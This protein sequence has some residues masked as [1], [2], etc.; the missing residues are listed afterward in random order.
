MTDQGTDQETDQETD[1]G[2]DHQSVRQDMAHTQQ[3][4]G[5]QFGELSEQLASLLQT[6]Q[7]IQTS[8]SEYQHAIQKLNKQVLRSGREQLKANSL[9]EA[10]QQQVAEALEMLQQADE[11]R[12]QELLDT[13]ERSK[14]AQTEARIEL[15]KSLLPALDGLDE[16]LRSGQHALAHL[17][18]PPHMPPGGYHTGDPLYAH[19]IYAIQQV[20]AYRQTMM[21]WLDGLFL[22]RERFLT[23]LRSHHVVPMEVVGRAF[24]PQ[25]HIAVDT[26]P[27]YQ[28]FPPGSIVAETRRGYYLHDRVLRFAE[29]IVA[30]Q[31]TG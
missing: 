19:I 31:H 17:P 13:I 4:M 25:Y 7:V 1:Q 23:V 14:A 24:D 20:A 16:A 27:A 10:Y 9:S 26:S 5:Q 15:V 21:S 2:T 28:A 8:V 18:V 30:R 6:Q 12:E 29:V 22:V 3:H 11:R